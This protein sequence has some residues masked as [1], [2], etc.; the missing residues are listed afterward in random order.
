MLDVTQQDKIRRAFH[1]GRL[2]VKS[3]S[4]RGDLAWKRVEAVHR[5]EVGPENVVEVTTSQGAAVLTGGHR[6][7]LAPTEKIEAERLQPG[8][9]SN[10][11]RVLSLNSLPPRQ[12]MYDVTAAD[13]HN[14]V[15]FRS[16]D[17]KSVV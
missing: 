12:Y 14:F 15:L 4:P 5:A 7:F 8:A 11:V 3:V 6:V 9:V 10:G 17:R 1:N 13:W 16:G 2:R